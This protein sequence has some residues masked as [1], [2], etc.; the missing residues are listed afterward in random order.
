MAKTYKAAF[1]QTPKFGSAVITA[2]NTLL[3]GSGT[4]AEVLTAGADGTQ[5]YGLYAGARATV[6]ATAVR[7][8]ISTDGGSSWKYL[9]EFDSLIPAHTVA[10]TTVNEGRVT[11]ID[12]ESETDRLDLPANAK[13]GAAIAVPL[14]GGV[15]V[16]AF[17]WDY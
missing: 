14:A 10:D 2:A 9:P 5:V 8:F 1:P 3:D 7:F 15:Q 12:R 11:V 16:A 4:I 6:T 13:L 17:G